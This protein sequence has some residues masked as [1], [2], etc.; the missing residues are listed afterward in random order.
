M[1][2]NIFICDKGI[3]CMFSNK[4]VQRLLGLPKEVKFPE[5]S[6]DSLNII[7]TF[8]FQ[9]KFK[10]WSPDDLDLEFFMR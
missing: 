2:I 4:E 6:C 5:E 9:H 8:P 7:Q 3:L 1:Y 10:L